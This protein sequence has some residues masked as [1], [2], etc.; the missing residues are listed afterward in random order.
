MGAFQ[1][2]HLGNPPA[3]SQM[4]TSKTLSPC[5][6]FRVTHKEEAEKITQDTLHGQVFIA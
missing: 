6:G 1:E 2:P 5:Q 4:G 3:P